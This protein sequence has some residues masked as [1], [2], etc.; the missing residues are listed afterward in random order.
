MKNSVG[1]EQ[2][3][4]GKSRIPYGDEGSTIQR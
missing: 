2:N 1:N 4:L 3:Q